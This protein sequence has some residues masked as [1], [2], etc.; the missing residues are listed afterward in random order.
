M[1]AECRQRGLPV[2]QKPLDAL[3]KEGSKA[4]A[5]V[6]SGVFEHLLD[7]EAFLR[8][9][10]DV[11]ED[12]GLLVSLQ[13]TGTFARLLASVWRFGDLN[14]PLPSIFWVFDPPWHVALYSLP[15]MRRLAEKNGF[16]L[17]DVRFAPQGRMEGLYGI[18]QLLLEYVNRVGWAFFRSAWPLMVSH[19]Y[20]FRKKPA[21]FKLAEARN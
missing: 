11:L 18:A 9:A 13:P 2:E 12:N 20:V 5:L 21:G 7:P 17:T 4:Q 8:N 15:G 10:Y 1:V 19:I 6:L 3:V 14:K 16:E